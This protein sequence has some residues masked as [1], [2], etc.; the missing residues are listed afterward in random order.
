[1]A[2]VVDVFC[3]AGGLTHG[4]VRQGFHVVAGI[5]VDVSCKYPYEKN[6]KALFI[7]KSV[8]ELRS[9]EVDAL[10]VAGQPKVLIGCAPCQPFSTYTYKIEYKDKWQLI[11]NFAQLIVD[12]QPDIFSMENVPAL[13]HY[14]G[15]EVFERF[16]RTLQPV[17]GDN[18]WRGR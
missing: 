10:F 12:V 16:I 4:F 18:I 15:G 3:G 1:M 11:D 14:K 5:D 13:V 2:S 17:Y 6:N 8:S 7:H 9:E